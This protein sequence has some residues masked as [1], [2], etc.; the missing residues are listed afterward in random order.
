MVVKRN[1]KPADDQ[2]PWPKRYSNFHTL[3][4]VSCNVS[5]RNGNC[6]T[7]IQYNVTPTAHVSAALPL[8]VTPVYQNRSTRNPFTSIDF[9]PT[10]ATD[11]HKIIHLV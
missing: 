8:Y 10:K 11:H 7:T 6:P 9:S 2:Q 5:P 3:S 4:Y 1:A